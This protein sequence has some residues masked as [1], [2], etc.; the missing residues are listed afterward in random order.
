[1]DHRRYLPM[2]FRLFKRPSFSKPGHPSNALGALNTNIISMQARSNGW[3]ICCCEAK[4]R[5]QGK[6]CQSQQTTT[7]KQEARSK[8]QEARSKGAR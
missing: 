2:A 5:G 8:K 7:R 1:M 3:A 6:S 4:A